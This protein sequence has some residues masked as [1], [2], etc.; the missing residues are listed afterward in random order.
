MQLKLNPHSTPIPPN[1]KRNE[2]KDGKNL[3]FPDNAQREVK[4][5]SS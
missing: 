2:K 1:H 4:K 5:D 3:I